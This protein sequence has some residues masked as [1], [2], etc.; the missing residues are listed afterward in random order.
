MNALKQSTARLAVFWV[1]LV[2]YSGLNAQDS[3]KTTIKQE[4]V[5]YFSVND[6]QHALPLYQ[7]LLETYPKEPV[8]QY[9]TALCLLN[10]NRNLDEA[11]G[12]FRAL[13]N[14]KEFPMAAFY[15]GRALHLQYSFE[16][17]IKAYSRFIASAKKSAV[18]R[19]NVQRYIEMAK[20][21]IELTRNAKAITVKNSTEVSLELLARSFTLSVNGKVIS[22]PKEF[23]TK[24]DQKVGCSSLMYLP[25]YTEINEY[26]YVSGYSETGRKGREIFRIKNINHQA[27]GM[28]ELLSDI[29]NTPYNEDYPFFDVHTSTLYF[30]SEGHSSMGG[31][32][33][34]KS[35]YDWNAKTWSKPQNL[36]FPI[37]SPYDDF[38]LVTD[39]LGL[40]AQFASNR[41]TSPGNVILYK[42]LMKENATELKFLTA[43]DIRE[44]S[45]LS[46]S[47]GSNVQPIPQQDNIEI[48][49]NSNH[50]SVA[51][52]KTEYNILIA[53]ALTLQLKADS[54]SRLAREQRTEVR[55]IT[56]ND[57]KKQ[58]I[59]DIIRCEKEAKKIQQQADEKFMAARKIKNASD[60]IPLTDLKTADNISAP[61]L[62][63]EK[64]LGDNS[65]YHENDS[66]GDRQGNE[67]TASDRR[68]EIDTGKPEIVVT[69]AAG[70]GKIISSLPDESNGLIYRIQLGVYSMPKETNAFSGLFPLFVE[71]LEQKN[72]YKYYTG[73]F[74]TAESVAIALEKV[75]KLGFPDAFVVAFYNG[76]QISTEKAR[77]IEF[78]RLKL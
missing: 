76:K 34:F 14:N 43:E 33:I 54:L 42:I 35:V 3:V 7:Q 74:S 1:C 67:K 12:L 57:V 28:P 60:T 53:E 73:N 55:N 44:I 6:F 61:D 26:V 39:E 13:I 56:D 72:V 19:L 62:T 66:A 49:K 24:Y 40:T 16:D 48:D 9:R 77:E 21:G 38:M 4:A 65:Q 11:A 59:G 5:R 46:E 31:Y 45:L 29:I 71:W 58:M 10:L 51:Y 20:N 68:D 8:Y 27:W 69:P 18:K 70:D 64:S 63:D 25:S 75:R 47:T 52:N 23:N 32:D 30:S 78:A 50:P 17:A 37:N 41:N 2:I 36:G 22:K 15:F